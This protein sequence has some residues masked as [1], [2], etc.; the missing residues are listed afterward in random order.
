MKGVRARVRR[1]ERGASLILAIAFLVVVG[2]ISSAVI[3]SVTS[4]FNG[5]TVLDRARDR[6]YAADGGI[7]YAV[8]QVRALPLPG[9]PGLAACAGPYT[10]TLN[11]IKIRIDC[12]NQPTITLGGFLQRNVVFSACV[13]TN[14]TC[15]D[16]TTVIRAQVN[17][18]AVSAGSIL[19]VSR[20]WVQ[21][22]SVNG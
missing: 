21:S 8:A 5:R 2:G 11:K 14:S 9:G 13:D 19:K 6:E 20:T 18:Q 10:N 4:G 15:T 22:W 7:E 12:A 17:F 1:D 3:S 16:A